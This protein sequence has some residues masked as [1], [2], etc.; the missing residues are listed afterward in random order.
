M[1]ATTQVA[2]SNP[3]QPRITYIAG[4]T[5][6]TSR[7]DRWIYL[8]LELPSAEARVQRFQVERL[9][10]PGPVPMLRPYYGEID[11][12]RQTHQYP[13]FWGRPGARYRARVHWADG[14]GVERPALS[15]EFIAPG[16]PCPGIAYGGAVPGTEHLPL[17]PQPP[18]PSRWPVAALLMPLALLPLRGLLPRR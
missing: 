8:D 12:P 18:P 5:T 1:A 10:L 16:L 13:A 17:I 2:N 6:D 9:D 15:H 4:T 7:C 3:P 11:D 14:Q